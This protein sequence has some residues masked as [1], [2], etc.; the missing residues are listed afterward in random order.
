MK[1]CCIND[2]QASVLPL[3]LL[4]CWFCDYSFHSLLWINSTF[5][6]T[7]IQA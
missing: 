4:C 6:Q 2:A 1:L 7:Q 3:F 5:G